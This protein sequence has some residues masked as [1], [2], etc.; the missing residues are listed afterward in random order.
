MAALKQNVGNGGRQSQTDGLVDSVN[1]ACLIL[2][3]MYDIKV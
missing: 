1:L 2:C 3:I